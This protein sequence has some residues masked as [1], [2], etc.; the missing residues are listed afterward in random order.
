MRTTT[1]KTPA[2]VAPVAP[3]ALAA[4]VPPAAPIKPRIT[5]LNPSN[6]YS[7][8]TALKLALILG[9]YD[10]QV[11]RDAHQLRTYITNKLIFLSATGNH[12]TELRALE[13]LGK[14]SD[15]GL[16]L[17]KS[18]ITVVHTDSA[19]LGESLRSKIQNILSRNYTPEERPSRSSA[20]EEHPVDAEF[21]DVDAE[22]D[23]GT[24]T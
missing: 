18:E 11:V 24:S 8:A 12:G 19:A 14:T 3:V 17:D 2:P 5:P 4:P 22:E 1:I 13:L 10:K 9:E 23:T 15:V 6:M 21:K 16:F 7:T 20:N